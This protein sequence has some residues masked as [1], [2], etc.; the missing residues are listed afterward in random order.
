MLALDCLQFP[1]NSKTLQL[2]EPSLISTGS[3]VKPVLLCGTL[4][5]RVL[6]ATSAFTNENCHSCSKDVDVDQ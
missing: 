5:G 3:G 6:T 1:S 2:D 4:W